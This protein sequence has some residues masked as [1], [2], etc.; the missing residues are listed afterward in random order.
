[1]ARRSRRV[2]LGPV[3]PGLP[4]QPDE[5][6]LG[7][8][9]RDVLELGRHR[10]VPSVEEAEGRYHRDQFDDLAVVEVRA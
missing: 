5:M 3:T 4:V 7:H 1:M 2:L 6:L 10:L 9:Q 8:G